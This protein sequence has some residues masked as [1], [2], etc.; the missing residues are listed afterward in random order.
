M[1]CIVPYPITEDRLRED[2][3]DFKR[4]IQAT[5]KDVDLGNIW[6]PTAAYWVKGIS[7]Y[8]FES[9]P[10]AFFRQENT[11]LQKVEQGVGIDEKNREYIEK[12]FTQF[13]ENKGI[14]SST[15]KINQSDLAEFLFR[16]FVGAIKLSAHDKAMLEAH[17]LMVDTYLQQN[18]ISM[19]EYI[20][21]TMSNLR[22]KYYLEKY[23]SRSK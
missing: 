15:E 14:T 23:V 16:Y 3:K 13:V 21:C 9:I 2:K 22:I 5:K 17:P 4:Y 20:V 18:K 7:T 8:A 10:Q 11:V 12:G 19:D 1:E 6:G